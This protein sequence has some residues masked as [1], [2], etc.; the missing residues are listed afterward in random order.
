VSGPKGAAAL[1]GFK[2]S[3]LRNRM[4]KLG[5]SKPTVKSRVDTLEP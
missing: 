5:I 3:T 4:I 1:L 2:T